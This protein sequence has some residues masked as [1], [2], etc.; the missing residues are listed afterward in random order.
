[1]CEQLVLEQESLH[2]AALPR[3]VDALAHRGRR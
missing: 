3:P 2:S 1:M